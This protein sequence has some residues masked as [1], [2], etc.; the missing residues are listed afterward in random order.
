[1]S[2]TYEFFAREGDEAPA[3]HPQLE[4]LVMLADAC[5]AQVEAFL[6]CVSMTAQAHPDSAPLRMLGR[7]VTATAELHCAGASGIL[8]QAYELQREL[9]ANQAVRDTQDSTGGAR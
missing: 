8:E 3:L 6:A 7:L 9:D 2:R 5:A 1:M 4:D